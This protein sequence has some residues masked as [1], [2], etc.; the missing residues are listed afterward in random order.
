MN[1]KDAYA[2]RRCGLDLEMEYVLVGP[3]L[4]AGESCTSWNAHD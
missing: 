3:T 1:A 4:S 2:D